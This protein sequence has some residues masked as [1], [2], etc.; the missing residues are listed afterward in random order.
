MIYKSFPHLCY[1]KDKRQGEALLR[2]LYF[3]PYPSQAFTIETK[4]TQALT[5]ETQAFTIAT[6]FASVEGS[7]RE[8]QL[9]IFSAHG[10]YLSK[11]Y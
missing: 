4:E 1:S 11:T 6:K 10:R 8:S 5:I 9:T 7:Q 2:A 3:P